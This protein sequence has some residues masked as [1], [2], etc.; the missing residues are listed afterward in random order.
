[1]RQR[2]SPIPSGSRIPTATPSTPNPKPVTPQ[3]D[4][5]HQWAA[6]PPVMHPIRNEDPTEF[7]LLS[8]R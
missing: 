7:T 2:L 6:S 4:R 3:S 5:D 8:S 1:L